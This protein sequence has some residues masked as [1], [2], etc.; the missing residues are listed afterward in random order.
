MK[1]LLTAV[2]LALITLS[3]LLWR[4]PASVLR[5]VLPP[6]TGRAVQ[7]H[8]VDGTVWQGSALF[9]AVA[10]PP[11]LPVTWSC[12]PRLWPLGIRCELGDAFAGRVAL[13]VLASEITA[14]RINATVPLRVN[15][16]AQVIAQSP[17]VL[18]EVATATLSRNRINIKG[19]LRAQDAIYRLGS[20]DI[21]LGEVSFDCTPAGEDAGGSVCT[22]AN[23]GGGARLDGRLLLSSR[24]ASGSVEL[25]PAGGAT[26]RFGF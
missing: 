3:V 5:L 16:G 2:A 7:L 20:T 25:T 9:T 11:A 26:Q 15:A 17:R 6:E 19:N 21:P 1:R 4:L 18:A 23:R 10:V 8:R 12:Q 24:G 14:E 22:L 13:N